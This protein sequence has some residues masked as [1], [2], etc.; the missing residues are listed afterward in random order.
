V[1]HALPQRP[2]ELRVH[3]GRGKRRKQRARK[4]VRLEDLW[5]AQPLG[6]DHH[7]RGEEE[8]A[9]GMGSRKIVLLV[10]R[11]DLRALLADPPLGA[12]HMRSPIS[13]GRGLVDPQTSA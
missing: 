3:L 11:V 13:G 9:R 4:L 2:E 8:H 5:A 1:L 6:H 10:V 12:R 7:Q